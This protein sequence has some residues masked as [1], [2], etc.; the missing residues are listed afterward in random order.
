M[1]WA[2]AFADEALIVG[3]DRVEYTSEAF[4]TSARS[5]AL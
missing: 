2:S 1:V 3:G 4:D 5:K